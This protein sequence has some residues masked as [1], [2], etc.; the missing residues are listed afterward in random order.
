MCGW[1]MAANRMVVA[2]S[3]NHALSDQHGPDR[4]FAD[5]CGVLR[6]VQGKTHE[7]R[8]GW[9]GVHLTQSTRG[10]LRTAICLCQYG[11]AEKNAGKKIRK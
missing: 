10:Q 7:N 4:Y 1:I 9:V 6:L 5:Q 11:T 2:G 3:Q 8:I